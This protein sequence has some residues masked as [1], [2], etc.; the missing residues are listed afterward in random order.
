MTT[1][2]ARTQTLRTAA[3]RKSEDAQARAR[4]ALLALENRG[5]PINFRSVAEE[6]NVSTGFLYSHPELRRQITERRQQPP[7]RIEPNPRAARSKEASAVVKLAVAADVIRQL[8]AENEQLR[9]ENATL[10]G[11]LLS[12]DQA[13]RLRD[14]AANR[15]RQS[16]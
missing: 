2:E 8:R 15:D 13:R 14:R 4:R 16:S 7:P 12:A 10:R 11:D 1:R 6:G 9:T 5:V 3:I